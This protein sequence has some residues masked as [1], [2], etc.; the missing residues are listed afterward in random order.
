VAEV[1]LYQVLCHPSAPEEA[2]PVERV[3]L[4]GEHGDG[5]EDDDKVESNCLPEACLLL[6]RKR[7]EE[8]AL[9]NERSNDRQYRTSQT[10]EHSAMY[11]ASQLLNVTMSP[12]RLLLLEKDI[13]AEM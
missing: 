8:L 6:L 9:S 2:E 7:C 1:E 3:L 11:S 13:S 12:P 5:D 4:G 10:S